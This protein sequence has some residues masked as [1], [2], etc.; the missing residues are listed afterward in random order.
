MAAVDRPLLAPTPQHPSP[1]APTEP[2]PAPGLGP[3]PEP[4]PHADPDREPHLSTLA[5]LSR[6]LTPTPQ[7]SD[8]PNPNPTPNPTPT[9]TPN[10]TPTPTPNPNQV[11]STDATL[12][13]LDASG[14]CSLELL[15]SYRLVL[16]G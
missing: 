7:A 4:G 9:P 8:N 13:Y 2:G 10:P 11:A 16:A 6:K 3:H 1:R 12:Y 14:T 5:H 15:R